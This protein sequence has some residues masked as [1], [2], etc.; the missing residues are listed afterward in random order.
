MATIK[1]MMATNTLSAI[2]CAQSFVRYSNPESSRNIIFTNGCD[3]D[4]PTAGASTLSLTKAALRSY[5]MTLHETVK[6]Q[7]IFSGL[8]TVEQPI[9]QSEEMMPDHITEAFW[10][11]TQKDNLLKCIIHVL[12]LTINRFSCS[13]SNFIW[14]LFYIEHF[15]IS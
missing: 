14:M 1:H 7:D 6:P 10:D 5:A 4:D 2:Q 12:A 11:L 8:V 9:V 13:A 15:R 3:G